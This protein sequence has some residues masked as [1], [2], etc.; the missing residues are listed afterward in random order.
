MTPE[1]LDEGLRWIWKRFYSKAGIKKRLGHYL[2]RMSH[3]DQ[4]IE[5]TNYREF[6]MEELMLLLNVAFKVAVT[7]F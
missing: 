7:D 1:E 4:P 6:S 5:S 3:I 2:S